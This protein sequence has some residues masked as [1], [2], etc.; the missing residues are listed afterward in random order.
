MK[1]AF[2]H[3]LESPHPSD[4]TEALRRVYTHVYDPPMDYTDPR[5]FEEVLSE[6]KKQKI[7]LLIGSSMGAWFAY[8]ISTLTGIPTLLFNPAVHSRSMNPKVRSGSIKSS[9]T[10]VFGKKDSVVDPDK[11]VE[12]FDKNGVGKLHYNWEPME[13][14]IPISVFMRWI[15]SPIPANRL[16]ESFDIWMMLNELEIPSGKWVDI[17]L[18]T[19]DDEGMQQIWSM[20]TSTYAK[21]GMDFS[22]DDYS[23]MRTKYKATFLKDVDR[24]K[25]PDAFIIH[26]PTK[27]GNKIAL[28]G[29][30]DKKEAKR[31]LIQQ[32]IKLVSTRGWFIEASLKM[33]EI[34]AASSAP[35]VKD[36]E[37]IREIVGADKKPE[38]EKDGY[39]TRLLSKASKRIQK[40]IYGILK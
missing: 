8:C 13:H 2:F 12:W 37:A 18:N 34:L 32:L 14:R 36:E 26:K 22:A 9:H 21:Q 24:D 1:V 35:V 5:L 28:L 27:W 31:D 38:M 19:I 15:K 23:E 16:V 30:N 20:Y 25:L 33:E 17:D 29:T 11:T 7:E 6:V 10:V 4:K 40:R 3:G 39:Y